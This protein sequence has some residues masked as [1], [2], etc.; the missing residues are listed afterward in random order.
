VCADRERRRGL[1]HPV[2]ASRQGAR[3]LAMDPTEE[4]VG[5]GEEEHRGDGGGSGAGGAP[6]QCAR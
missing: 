6:R 3:M 2:F 4:G 5:V 1:L